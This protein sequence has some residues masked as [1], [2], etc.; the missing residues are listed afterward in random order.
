MI[1]WIKLCG[2]FQVIS[3]LH[4]H[5]AATYHGLVTTQLCTTASQPTKY[6]YSQGKLNQYNVLPKLR[7]NILEGC[8][9]GGA[10]NLIKAFGPAPFPKKNSAIVT[11]QGIYRY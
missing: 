2:E 9:L 7:L 5:L 6:L 3:T 8:G 1:G 10:C 4:N 11:S